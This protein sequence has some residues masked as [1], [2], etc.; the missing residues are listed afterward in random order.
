MLTLDAATLGRFPAFLMV[1]E[2]SRSSQLG[3]SN[4]HHQVQ[5][6]NKKVVGWEEIASGSEANSLHVEHGDGSSTTW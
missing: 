5:P 4:E 6:S 3:E 1:P 2:P